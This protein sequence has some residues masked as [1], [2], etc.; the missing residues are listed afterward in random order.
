[1]TDT[2][3]VP[4]SA[5]FYK[6]EVNPHMW[7]SLELSDF[8]KWRGKDAEL[9]VDGSSQAKCASGDTLYILTVSLHKQVPPTMFYSHD[10]SLL[11]DAV[12][13]LEKG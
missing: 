13:T 6:A 8:L 5:V 3:Y 12:K 7:E 9:Y 1:M 11:N 4:A 10:L 2:L